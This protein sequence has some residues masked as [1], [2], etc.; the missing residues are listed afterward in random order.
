[1][2]PFDLQVNGYAGADF[3]SLE[4]TTEDLHSGCQALV[5][6]G[7]DGI[8]ATVITDSIEGLVRKLEHLV[9]LRQKD[10]I[11][12]NLIAGFHIEG[13]FLNSA[14]GFIGAHS[15]D[16]VKPGNPDDARRLWDASHGLAKLVT[17]APENDPGFATTQFFASRDVVV[18]AGHCDPT[19]DQLQ[20]AIDHGLTM[21]TH[22][23]NGCPVELPRHDN[24]LQRMLHLRDQLWFCFIPDG[25]HIDFVA[26]RNY[27]DFVGL[28]RTIMTTDAI[29]ATK[30]DP[31]LHELS[32]LV[33]EVD[34]EGIARRPG[35]RN[36]A[37]STITMPTLCRN[38]AE[39]L[40]LS[41]TEI[42]R[43]VDLNPRTAIFAE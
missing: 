5:E 36:L 14:P 31:G 23:G 24:A 34:E 30:L 3:C 33:I 12:R 16:H 35:S 42:E 1:M 26:L 8:L 17:L 25:A 19:V 10:E 13:P 15:P 7:F 20:G 11:A 2:K 21:I 22:F 29:A 39:H 4:L 6:D 32:G 27:I 40:R 41:E 9:K 18:S 38:L 43:V 37:G 28:D